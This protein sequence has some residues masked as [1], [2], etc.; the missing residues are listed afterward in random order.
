MLA[1]PR[2]VAGECVRLTTL[3][4]TMCREPKARTLTLSPPT[5]FRAAAAVIVASRDYRTP[6]PDDASSP[7]DLLRKSWSP[8]RRILVDRNNIIRDN[9]HQHLA[10][11]PRATRSIWYLQPTITKKNANE[12]PIRTGWRGGRRQPLI[13]AERA[14]ALVDAGDALCIDFPRLPERRAHCRR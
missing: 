8:H 12:L 13:S 4:R 9:K 14:P 10:S 11:V 7:H 1:A 5:R 6:H 2:R 3:F